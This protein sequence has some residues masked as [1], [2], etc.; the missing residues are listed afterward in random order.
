MIVTFF[1][2]QSAEDVWSNI[3]DDTTV[4]IP[5]KWSESLGKES[6]FVEVEDKAK[7]SYLI[8]I[9]LTKDDAAAY[10]ETHKGKTLSLAQT[11]LRILVKTL[12][13][14]YS[15]RAQKKI[16]CVIFAKDATDQLYP[17]DLA[18]SSTNFNN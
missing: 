14:R 15:G 7:Q 4:Y 10:K 9:F 17:I 12:E 11:K 8:R 3:T 18:W 5:I 2:E 1:D 13:D 6:M 16:Y